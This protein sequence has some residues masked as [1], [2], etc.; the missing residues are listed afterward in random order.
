M[1]LKQSPSSLPPILSREEVRE[2]IVTCERCPRLRAYCKA[3]GEARRR[4]YHDQIYWAKP[5]PGF[6]DP[7]ARVLIAG[8]APGAHGAN[9]TG[10]PFTGDGS[11]AFMYPVL[12]DTGFA[13]QTTAISREDGLKLRHAWIASVVRCAPPK[14]KPLP[15][16][17]RNCSTHFAAEISQ[18]PRLRVVVGLGRIAWDGHLSY[19]LGKGVIAKRSAYPFGH[20]A[21]YLLPNGLHLLGTYHPSLRNTN[22]GLLN[23]DMFTRI[24]VRA[25]ELA[26]LF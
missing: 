3:I 19:L 20:G 6:G 14:D 21:E 2:R 4:A 26:G 15:E 9:R 7:K 16:E 25:R 18:L 24:F 13:N 1:L 11:G 22:T 12:Y 23:R 8:L 5:V 17:L 10:R